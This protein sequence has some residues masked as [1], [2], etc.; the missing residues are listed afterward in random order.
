[1]S[2][3]PCDEEAAKEAAKN[4]AKELPVYAAKTRL[5]KTFPNF[6]KMF[7]IFL[8]ISEGFQDFLS[9]LRHFKLCLDF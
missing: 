8:H 3:R 1:M 4:A 9:L 5:L 2:V 6:H 7:K